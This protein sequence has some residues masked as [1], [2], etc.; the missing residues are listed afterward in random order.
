[1]NF[2]EFGKLVIEGFYGEVLVNGEKTFTGTGR[3]FMKANFEVI[4]K[5]SLSDRN[6]TDYPNGVRL[7]NEEDVKKAIKEALEELKDPENRPAI[8]MEKI[9]F[10]FKDKF[11]ER[12]L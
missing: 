3:E 12:L 11:G 10:V 4:E 7:Y 8:P 1:M 5:K 2:I 9:R 6:I